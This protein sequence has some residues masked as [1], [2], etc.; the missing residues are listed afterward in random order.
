MAH[1]Y[2]ALNFV[3][4]GKYRDEIINNAFDLSMID[5]T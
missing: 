2:T 1:A 3:E 4:N 5:I